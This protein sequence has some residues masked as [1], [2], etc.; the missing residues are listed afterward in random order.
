[1]ASGEVLKFIAMYKTLDLK[2]RPSSVLC[3]EDEYTAYCFDEAVS[4]IVSRLECGDK[5]LDGR[6]KPEP[7]NY[8]KPSDLYKK[9]S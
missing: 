3:I 1:M 5:V 9:Y 6:G 8:S 2:E 7:K 4:L